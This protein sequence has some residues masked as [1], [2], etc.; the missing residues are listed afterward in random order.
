MKLCSE[1]MSIKVLLYRGRE[2][3]Y[4]EAEKYFTAFQAVRTAAASPILPALKSLLRWSLH[5]D[6]TSLITQ[7]LNIQNMDSTILLF[8]LI[9]CV[10]IKFRVQAYL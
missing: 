4:I 5:V 9:H 10:L 1:V 2:I 7:L 8:P 3:F 6:T